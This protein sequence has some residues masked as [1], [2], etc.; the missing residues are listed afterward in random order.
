MMDYDTIIFHE[1]AVDNLHISTILKLQICNTFYHV[2]IVFV[3]MYFIQPGVPSRASSL[4]Q[5]YP[6]LLCINPSQ[7]NAA[8]SKPVFM[9]NFIDTCLLTNSTHISGAVIFRAH[10]AQQTW[11]GCG[12][13]RKMAI[14]DPQESILR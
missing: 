10:I 12:N 5:R 3:C 1:L 7:I 9:S 13:T 14:F 4:Y 8:D 11:M 6:V 2:A